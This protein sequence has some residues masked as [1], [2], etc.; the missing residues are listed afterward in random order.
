MTAN[1]RGKPGGS[2]RFAS[3]PNMEMLFYPQTLTLDYAQGP[4]F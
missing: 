2:A 4:D 3:I 1:R